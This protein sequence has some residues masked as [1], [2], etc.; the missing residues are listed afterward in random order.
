MHM[1]SDFLGCDENYGLRLPRVSPTAIKLEQ[2]LR[3]RIA[4]NSGQR[5]PA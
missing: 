4:A 3:G 2:R 1:F 5:N